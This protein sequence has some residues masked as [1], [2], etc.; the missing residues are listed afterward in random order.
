VQ[1][2]HFRIVDKVYVTYIVCNNGIA[3]RIMCELLALNLQFGSRAGRWPPNGVGELVVDAG[4]PIIQVKDLR[5]SFGLSEVLRGIT[6]D[7][8]PGSVLSIIGASGSG[9]STFL[10]CLN[11]LERPTSGDIVIDG[12]AI[13]P[14]T[15]GGRR[16][17]G[18]SPRDI[19]RMRT[20]L[21]MVFQQFNLWPH[22]TVLGNV[23]EALIQVKRMPRKEAADVGR[24]F[25]A[26]VNLLD[27]E[28]AYPAKLSGG[29]QQRVA[30][31]RAL[32]MQ[33]KVMLFDEATS[34][35]DPELTG[36]VLEVM[37]DLAREGM[38]M[39]VVT[40]EMG[41]ARD[42]SDRV[43]FLHDG[44]IEE[45]GTAAQVFGAPSSE[46]CQRFISSALG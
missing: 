7:V 24:R 15:A 23:I 34:S 13:G 42:A 28:G 14:S 35:L 19:A 27:K 46:R 22:M 3:Q 39:L 26:K 32:A 31:A 36:E 2:V 44:K 21:G 10:R 16:T 20:K 25:L 11:Y 18:A 30:I 5:K 8:S 29:Q 37:R 41:F 12:E 45:D 43:I 9:K 4:R 1:C 33:P 40:H 17:S 6:L 38:T